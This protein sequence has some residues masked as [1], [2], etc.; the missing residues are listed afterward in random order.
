M[1]QS[2]RLNIGNRGIDPGT[3]ERYEI[4]MRDGAAFP[5]VCLVSV[6]RGRMN[7]KFGQ[8]RHRTGAAKKRGDTTVEAYV[9]NGLTQEQEWALAV[10]Y[11]QTNGRP[12]S[13]EEAIAYAMETHRRF[14]ELTLESIASQVC[15]NKGTLTHRIAAEGI[16]ETLRSAGLRKADSLPSGTLYALNG[17]KKSQPALLEAARVV[18][19]DGMSNH[20]AR[21]FVRDINSQTSDAARLNVIL[22]R[23]AATPAPRG[24]GDPPVTQRKSLPRDRLTKAMDSL[25]RVVATYQDPKMLCLTTGHLHRN[26][27][28]RWRQVRLDVNRALGLETGEV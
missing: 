9:V 15:V 14:P 26:A 27:V 23:D 28:E 13:S 17:L 22:R 7:Y 21:E 6:S 5:P 18:I 8:G 3:E 24:T 2:G 16:R 10:F 12:L 4:A 1:S 19:A 20:E 25:A 11:N